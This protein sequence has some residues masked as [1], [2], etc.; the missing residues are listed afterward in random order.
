MSGSRLPE[1]APLKVGPARNKQFAFWAITIIFLL[2]CIELACFLVTRFR[3]DLFD[4]RELIVAQLGSADFERIQANSASDLLGWD[5]P[6]ST[7]TQTKNCA[8]EE[9]TSTYSSDRIRLHGR[10]RPHDAVVLIAGDSFT[11]GNE[12]S[13]QDTYPAQ[14]ERILGVPTANLGVSGY[15]PD[16]ALLKL[17][18]QIENFPRAKVVILSIGY[19][20]A[21]YMLNSFRPL[22]QNPTGRH[23]GLKPY[24]GN[25]TFH[26]IIGGHPYRSF[27]AFKGAALSAFDEDYWRRP[28]PTFPYLESVVKMIFLPSF[29]VPTLTQITESLG[30]PHYDLLHR[31]PSVQSGLRA[32]YERFMDWSAKR[33]LPGIVV[34][35]PT[36]AHDRTSGL[37]AIAAATADQRRGLTFLNVTIGD[38]STYMQQTGCH[39]SPAGYRTI[40]RS[41]ADVAR[42]F[43]VP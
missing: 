11:H 38:G 10:G 24:V 31:I 33:G 4:Q 42:R 40:A 43:V 37:T 36:D 19:A 22:V 29:W 26:E 8:G 1:S 6:A 23:F 25:G 2:V 3:P 30:R 28:R 27:E 14:L 39:P 34:F 7:I 21:A 5:N 9:V 15:G 13:D 20:G 12:V 17:E 41:V 35:I 16:Q 32:I 18:T